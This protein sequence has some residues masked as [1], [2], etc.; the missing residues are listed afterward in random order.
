MS[1][2]AHPRRPSGFFARRQAAARARYDVAESA[3]SLT[4][5]TTTAA[6]AAGSVPPGM[7]IAGAWAWRL[8][9]IMG[10]LAALL[11]VLAQFSLVIIPLLI[12]VVLSALLVPYKNF[13]VRHHWPRWLAIVV[14][15]L[16]VFIVIGALGFL[17]T[18]QISSGYADLKT[19]STNSYNMLRDWLKT[20]P[21]QLSDD[22]INGYIGQAFQAIQN[23]SSALVSGAL[24]VGSTLTHVLTGVLL[25]LF[26]T[27]FILIDGRG[28]WAFVVRIF[29]KRARAG[30]DGAGTAGWT[31]LQSF[32]KVQILVAFVD[33]VGIG[34]GAFL[35]GVPL[36]VPVAVLVFLGSF[37]PVVG[38]VLTGV[39]AIFIAL[40]YNGW[41]IA[42]AM[43]GVVLLVQQIEGHVLQPLVMGTA[44][45]VHPLAVVLAVAGG[46]IIAGIPGAFFAVPFIATLNVMVKYIASGVW[47]ARP[48]PKEPL[49]D[50]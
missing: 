48:E 18:T 26:S 41:P 49:P 37:I 40:V 25:V 36:A 20:G 6:A 45:K 16:T 7:Q 43:L 46:S 2:T 30:V 22:Q 50:A 19:Q 11:F 39:V 13:L 21:L 17:V 27:L 9:V 3:A 1:G 15:I 31:T 35:L 8:L 14:S 33:A 38:A 5:A 44:V 23:D 24:S 10:A 28:I 32:V 47:H 12:A 29:P 4:E 42:L 34:L